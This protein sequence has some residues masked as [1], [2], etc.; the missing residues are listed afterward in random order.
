MTNREQFIEDVKTLI[1]KKEVEKYD[2]IRKI[3]SI[4]AEIEN[5]KKTLK[6]YGK[7]K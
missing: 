2:L 7:N 5:Y 1:T 6:K 4:E 3:W